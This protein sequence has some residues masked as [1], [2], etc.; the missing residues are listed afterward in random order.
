LHPESRQV[1]NRAFG[2]RLNHSVELPV[3]RALSALLLTSPYVPLLWMGQEWAATTPFLYFT[4]HPE[5]LG[6][7]VTRGRREE[8]RHFSA[9][10]DPIA[11]AGIPDPQARETFERSRLLWEERGIPSH[12]G[13]LRLYRELLRLRNAHP[14]MRSHD[15]GSFDVA[16]VGEKALV[17]RRS[18]PGGSV[19]LVA[20]NFDGA[21]GIDLNRWAAG[22]PGA[23]PWRLILATEDARFG[24]SGRWGRLEGEGIVDFRETGAVIVET[25]PGGP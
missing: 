9:F 4:D 19:L 10:R 17:I 16:A 23:A 11:A 14:G 22:D 13:V 15:R 7:L 25:T 20:V 24:G 18:G 3:Y 5:E 6:R 8:F 12:A 2:E 1:G 21:V